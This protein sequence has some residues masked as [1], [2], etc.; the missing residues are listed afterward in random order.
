MCGA[1]VAPSCREHHLTEATPCLPTRM[2]AFTP[3]HIFCESHRQTPAW[4]IAEMT[5]VYG[6]RPTAAS[7]GLA[8]T[9]PALERLSTRVS[10]STR[11]I[12]TLLSVAARTTERTR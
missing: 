8:L 11:P 10:R 4:F 2:S 7:P 3:T 6:N 5:A 1:Q 12:P 9:T